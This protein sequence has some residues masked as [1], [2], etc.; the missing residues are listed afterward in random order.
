MPQCG[1][2]VVFFVVAVCGVSSFSSINPLDNR[3]KVTADLQLEG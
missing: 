1:L 3:E 2:A